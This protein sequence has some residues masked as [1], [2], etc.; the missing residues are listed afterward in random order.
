MPSTKSARSSTRTQRIK[1]E[2]GKKK[3]CSSLIVDGSLRVFR[4]EGDHRGSKKEERRGMRVKAKR[5][6]KKDEKMR[7]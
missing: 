6:V 2:K 5:E 3:D 4:V 7:R 1:K